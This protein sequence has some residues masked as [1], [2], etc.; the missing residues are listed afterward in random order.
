MIKYKL[1]DEILGLKEQ[2]NKT[3]AMIFSLAERPANQ[4]DKIFLEM[5]SLGLLSGEA[6]LFY[7]YIDIKHL[8]ECLMKTREGLT[9]KIRDI[10]KRLVESLAVKSE[11][12]K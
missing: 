9:V 2:L 10:E 6:N 8:H 3:E 1:M 7:G 12:E 5:T 4:L 11:G